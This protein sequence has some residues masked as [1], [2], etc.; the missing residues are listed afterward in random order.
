M[1]CTVSGNSAANSGGGIYDAG[2]AVLTDTIVA[3]NT[4]AS[5]ADDI[6]GNG[7]VNGSFNLIG[8]GGSGGIA[9]GTSGNIVLTTDTEYSS[10]NPAGL[11]PLAKNGGQTETMALLPA[12]PAIGVGTTADYPNTTN[13]IT[14]DQ[15]R[16]RSTRLPTSALI[17][18]HRSRLLLPRRRPLRLR[19]RL[20]L[21]HPP[22]HP[23]QHQRRQQISSLVPVLPTQLTSTRYPELQAPAPSEWH[24]LP[25][26]R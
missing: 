14:T 13:P 17:R 2:S 25:P 24:P 21:R 23:L 1:A 16:S 7:S 26:S 6:N 5:G 9:G 4:G 12:S 8:T 22:R 11:G 20:R 15:R 10:S 3:G 19:L 18:A